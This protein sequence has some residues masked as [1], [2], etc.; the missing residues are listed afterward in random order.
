MNNG[1]GIVEKLKVQRRK[2]CSNNSCNKLAK[3]G[4]YDLPFAYETYKLITNNVSVVP[5]LCLPS[6]R[7]MKE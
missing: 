5:H 4:R 3:F 7:E 2:K 1:N 6:E